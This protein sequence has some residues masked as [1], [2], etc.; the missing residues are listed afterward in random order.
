VDC[1]LLQLDQNIDL[2][3]PVEVVPEHRAEEP[4][5]SSV[6]SLRTAPCSREVAPRPARVKGHCVGECVGRCVSCVCS[7]AFTGRRLDYN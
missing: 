3:V 7:P 2:A 4:K 6:A 5:A 1:A